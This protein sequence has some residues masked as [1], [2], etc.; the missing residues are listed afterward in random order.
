MDV[1][2]FLLS[3]FLG[4]PTPLRQL[5]QVTIA[6]TFLYLSLSTTYDTHYTRMIHAHLH[7][8]AWRVG[9]SKSYDSKIVW[10]SSPTVFHAY[11]SQLALSECIW[12]TQSY[13]KKRKSFLDYYRSCLVL[14]KCTLMKTW[15]QRA[16][17]NNKFPLVKLN[18]HRHEMRA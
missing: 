15:K 11:I 6:H 13:N 12:Y 7:S 1:W 9:G 10:Y 8:S 5:G 18:E 4:P 3:S 2:S 16:P 14:F 17:K